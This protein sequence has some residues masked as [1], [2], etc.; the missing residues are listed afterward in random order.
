[1]SSIE[2]ELDKLD[3]EMSAAWNQY[4][5]DGDINTLDRYNKALRRFNIIN[6]TNFPE[7]D[8]EYIN[9]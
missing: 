1:M 2:T 5:S 4:L 6:K 7:R 3:I 9:S 8:K